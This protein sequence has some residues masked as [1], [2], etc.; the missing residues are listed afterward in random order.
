MLLCLL[1]AQ[2]FRLRVLCKN[3]SARRTERHQRPRPARPPGGSHAGSHAVAPRTPLQRPGTW[4]AAR[5]SVFRDAL[6]A[7]RVA[8]G[9]EPAS[10]ERCP[11]P[12]L[13][14]IPTQTQREPLLLPSVRGSRA[15]GGPY[16]GMIHMVSAADGPLWPAAAGPAAAAP[17]LLRC[18]RLP[19]A[20]TCLMPMPVST[21]PLKYHATAMSA[22]VWRARKLAGNS[23]QRQVAHRSLLR[24]CCGW[25][26][27]GTNG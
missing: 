24:R 14:R 23:V 9:R 27:C 1:A 11:T 13:G 18:C 3:S 25:R 5:S 22:N 20:C 16:T 8:N 10:T 19:P 6:E 12:D 4:A 7:I 2:R 15:V 17:P 26:R 21:K